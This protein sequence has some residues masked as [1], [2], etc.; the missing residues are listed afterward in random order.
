MGMKL[1]W[2]GGLLVATALALGACA[3]TDA[4]ADDE[5]AS[6]STEASEEPSMA[7]ESA[8][9]APTEGGVDEY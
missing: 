3:P 4:G 2:T 8:A 6:P 5:S 7:P 9:P 1:R